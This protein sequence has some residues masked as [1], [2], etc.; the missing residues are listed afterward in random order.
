MAITANINVTRRIVER[1]VLAGLVPMIHG[2]PAIGKSEVVRQFA[3][4]Y[5][6]KLIDIRLSQSDPTDLNGFP[7]FNADGTRAGYAPMDTFPLEGDTIPEGY[8][9][10]LIFFDEISS[11]P[12]SVQAAAYKILLDRMIG[13]RKL[14]KNVA[15]VGAGN[16][17]TDNAIVEPM[18]TALQSRMVH[19]EMVVDADLWT[20]WAGYKGIDHRILSF[21]RFK[22]DNIYQFD[23]DHTDKTY[24]SPRTWTMADKL[25]NGE[26]C[27]DHES[28]VL[29]AGTVGEGMAREFIGY[30][31]IFDQLP[32]FQQ[33]K[34]MPGTIP[35]PDEPSV[36]FALSGSLGN[37]IRSEA[38][39]GDV[40]PFID[41]MPAEF[42]VTT[43]RDVMRRTPGLE[44]T[45]TYTDWTIE[46]AE[47]FF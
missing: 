35:V 12:Q 28:L 39:L 29:L 4:D 24:A 21:I 27:S 43:M 45:E 34:K 31:R 8:D 40:L 42:A 2:S 13:Q 5:N 41:R 16:L 44:G 11:A 36:L 25:I 20:E 26:Q 18:S 10:W 15:M 23:P 14:H 3:E 46:N 37:Q 6:L 17:E 7:A 9:G 33:I 47:K 19:V 22:P 1:A 32:T 30:T 38:M